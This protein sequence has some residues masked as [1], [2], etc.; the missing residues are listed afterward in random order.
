[1]EHQFNDG[2]RHGAGFVGDA[3]D[4][5]ARSVAIVTGKSYREVY[6]AINN[7]AKVERR[8]VRKRG[9]SSSRTCDPTPRTRRRADDETDER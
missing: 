3:R 9:R 2:G 5:A 6:D 4:C 7:M 1:M 8:G